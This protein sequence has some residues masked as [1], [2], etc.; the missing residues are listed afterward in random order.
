MVNIHLRYLKHTHV[1]LSLVSSKAII[2]FNFHALI[3]VKFDAVLSPNYHHSMLNIFLILLTHFRFVY[4]NID[5]PQMRKTPLTSK[6][7]SDLGETARLVCE[8]KGVPNVTFSWSRPGGAGHVIISDYTS[9]SA[10]SEN[11]KYKVN[12]VALDPLVYR[13]EFFIYNVTH[14]DY[15]SYECVARNSEGV[16]RSQV[17]LDVKSRPDPPSDLRVLNVTNR[18]V[19]LAWVPGFHGGMDQYFR[20]RFSRTDGGIMNGGGVTKYDDVYPANAD[21]TIL[22]GLEPGV[23]YGLSIMAF[24][25]I[26]E[27]NYTSAPQVIVRTASEYY[28]LLP[29]VLL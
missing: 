7:A 14:K 23:Q 18:A 27:S 10:S 13:S 20:I 26:G 11:G 16:G 8:A 6:S 5:K 22:T 24:N 28:D 19:H 1:K 9:A 25:N 3:D 29:Y 21:Q 15:G 12:S 4:S 17:L 2:A